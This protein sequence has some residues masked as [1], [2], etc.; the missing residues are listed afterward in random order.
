MSLDSKEFR[1]ALSAFPTGVAV[2][3][4]L[5]DVGQPHGLTVSSFNSVSLDPPMI[6]WSQSVHAPSHPVFLSATGFVV[7]ILAEDQAD[8]SA[9]FSRGGAD[10]FAGVVLEDS[11]D[12]PPLLAGCSATFECVTEHRYPGGDHTIFVGAVRRF[13][14]HSHRPLVYGSGRYLIAQPG[15]T[16]EN[17]AL[18]DV[19]A[20]RMATPIA[21]ELAVELGE[22]VCISVWGNQGPTVIRWEE[23]RHPVSAGLKTGLV[24][25]L[26]DS[27]TGRVFA[28]HLPT[29]RIGGLLDGQEAEAEDLTRIRRHGVCHYRSSALASVYGGEVEA[30][31]VPVLNAA[32]DIVL[33]LTIVRRTDDLQRPG[34]VSSLSGRLVAEAARL[35]SRLAAIPSD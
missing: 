17:C 21:A 27:A 19:R 14:R 6:L 5:D 8:L 22:S 23:S 25:P 13:K 34:D 24:L 31:S 18:G 15:Q 3:T 30:V 26:L 33:A 20:V 32:G 29:D 35:S 1:R 9:Q 7:N 28:A 2:V 11:R 4:T 16:G 12:G 10:K